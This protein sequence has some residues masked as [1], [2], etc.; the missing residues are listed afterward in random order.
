[1]PMWRRKDASSRSRCFC[2][3]CCLCLVVGLFFCGTRLAKVVLPDPRGGLAR[4]DREIDVAQH[5]GLER[6]AETQTLEHDRAAA[7]AEAAGVR[8]F[9]HVRLG[10]EILEH[11]V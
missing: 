5:R 6:V 4:R 7:F 3:L 9:G 2:L 1:M 10:V 8:A 11:P